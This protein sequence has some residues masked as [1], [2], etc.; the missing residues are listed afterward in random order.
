MGTD[1]SKVLFTNVKIIDGTADEAYEGEVLVQGNEIA[2]VEHGAGKLSHD[3]AAVID[4]RGQTLMSG[5]CDA[6]THLSWNSGDL[7]SIAA[8]E[9]EEHMIVC[10]KSARILLDAGY[11]MCVGAAAAKQRLDVVVRDAINAGD[12]PGP[13][14]LASAKEIASPAGML[15]PGISTA[16]S[17]VE[18]MRAA[19]RTAIGLGVEII[20]LIQSGESITQRAWAKDDYFTDAEIAV[21]VEEAHRVGRRVA[22]HAR[23]AES[24]LKAV[25]N[26]IDILY[27][28]SYAD[29]ECV[30]LMEQRKDELFVAPGL[31]WLYASLYEA[32]PFG[33][34]QEAAEA[35][36][37][38]DE[39]DASIVTLKEMHRRGIKVLPGG[40]YGFAWTPHGTNARDLQHF[41]D[42][43][44][45]TP[46]AA[47]R[48][49]T[50]YGGEIMGQPD[51]LGRV[52]A[53]YLADLLLVDGDP[54]ADVAVLQNHDKLVGIMKDGRFH[55][56]PAPAGA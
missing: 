46:M 1:S 5:L 26:G 16:V 21:A 53:G 8:M 18:E 14:Y 20:K 35:V 43:L 44:G 15:V 45:F 56:S 33:F 24:C 28:M 41:V 36:G 22:T 34:S 37:Y 50:V 19:V 11:T 42:L 31:H 25:R 7:D 2:A 3:D 9:V 54:L 48:A 32:E 13:R 55:K 27:H 51:K 10:V 40:D 38:K 29:A 39:L 6:H 17:G 30:D 49:A 47:I 12:I 23:S 52:A 4:G